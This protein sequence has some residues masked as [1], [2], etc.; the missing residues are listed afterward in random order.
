M[1]TSMVFS[2]CFHAECQHPIERRP[3]SAYSVL[4]ETTEMISSFLTLVLQ[5]VF[6]GIALAART[7]GKISVLKA[8]SWDMAANLL[9]FWHLTTGA[10]GCHFPGRD[11]LPGSSAGLQS[12]CAMTD[13]IH[14]GV[15]AFTRA[16]S[17]G[18]PARRLWPGKRA[19]IKAELF[20]I[21]FHNERRFCRR[22]AGATW[23]RWSLSQRRQGRR[24][25]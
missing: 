22:I 23:D 8:T 14:D 7:G 4:G 13:L 19:R 1:V 6:V 12:G 16:G 5:I 11:C 2:R 20:Q 17:G 24:Y 18:S 10:L 3:P 9:G 25:P 21:A 15:L